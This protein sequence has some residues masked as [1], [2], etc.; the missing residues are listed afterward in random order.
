MWSDLVLAA[1]HAHLQRLMLWGG[2]SLVVG[3]LLLLTVA[4]PR[5]SALLFHFALQT[6]AWGAVN[7]VLAASGVRGL[8]ARD[9]S[10]ATRL[11][12]FLWL[13]V[14]LDA[15]YAA[16]GVTIALS[17]WLLGRRLG[18]IGAGVAVVIQGLALLLLD[19]RFLLFLERSV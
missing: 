9:L 12:R 8:V 1:E 2:G 11:D 16:V 19:T 14:G 7:L 3:A 18:G 4:R 6:A 10:A 5:R 13:N 15:G 17:A